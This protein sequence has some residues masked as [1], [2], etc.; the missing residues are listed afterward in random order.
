[1]ATAE[2]KLARMKRERGDVRN[3]DSARLALRDLKSED[4]IFSD[5][6]DYLGIPSAFDYEE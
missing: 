1:M 4:R 3:Q 6:I 2:T 5:K